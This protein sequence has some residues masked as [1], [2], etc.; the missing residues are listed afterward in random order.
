VRDPAKP[1]DVPLPP[2]AFVADPMAVIE[3]PDVD[4]VCE[5]IGGL[6][7]AGSLVLAAF[8]RDKPVVTANKELLATRGRELFDASDDKGLD[9]Y[10]EASV[11]GGIPLIRPLKESLTGERVRRV[12]GIVNG[13]TNFILTKMSE[14]GRA[15]D[16]VLAQAQRLGYAEADPT[17][18]VEGHDAAA[19][20]AI[21][22]SI[23]FNARVVA[24][25]VYREGIANVTTEDIEFARRLGYV[26]K[27]LAIAEMG[28][29]ERISA[30]VHAAMIPGTHPLA[31]VRDAYNAVFVEGPDVGELMFYGRGAGGEATATAV[32][33]DLVTVARNL[34]AGARG[35]GCTCFY[36]RTIRPDRGSD[37]PVLPAAPRRGPAGRTRR[38]RERVRAQRRLDQERV[39]GGVRR[40]RAAGVHHAPRARGGVPG[41]GG[42]PARPARRRGG[43]K[44]PAGG[45][46]GVAVA[47]IWRG[48]IQEYRDRL[49]VSD[50]TPVVTLGEGGTPLVRSDSLSTQTG[51]EV[52]L[53]YEGANPT[54]SFKDRGMTLAISKA[55]EE[56]SKAVVCASTGNTSASAAA[57]AGK[58]GLTCAV[59]VPKGKVAPGKMAGTLA[60]GARV[61]EVE[62]K[63]RRVARPRA[64]AGRTPPGDARELG[65]PAPPAGPEDVRVRDRGRARSRARRPLSP[66]RQRGQHREPLDG[67]LGV[68]G[69]R[70]IHEP[71]RVF[72]FQASGAAPW[73]WAGR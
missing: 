15:F 53:K 21:L 27:L 71:P 36:E 7:P 41:G 17:A 22:A 31:S 49:P 5:V 25:D 57:Y 4:I 37:G 65:E 19:K 44:R 8:D 35:V 51:C 50:A 69:R 42:R 20:C 6:E 72:G 16:D 60:H 3:D 30:R 70:L 64:R 52:Y 46:R 39:A 9:L 14:D 34:L 54:A 33:G 29:D 38:D 48:V 32:V 67:L 58:A 18:D 66:G 11:G 55:V 13:T 59:L 61:L 10:F 23:A 73:C 24:G 47:D 26:I 62:G 63:L 68:P 43:P 12:M 2:D 56:G 28:A 40:R 45:G 1:R